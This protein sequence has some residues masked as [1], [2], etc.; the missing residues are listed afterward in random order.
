MASASG[1]FSASGSTRSDSFHRTD[2]L[3]RAH[4]DCLCLF[5]R[6]HRGCVTLEVDVGLVAHVDGDYFDQRSESCRETTVPG[7]ASRLAMRKSSALRTIIGIPTPRP[8][9]SERGIRPRPTGP[10]TLPRG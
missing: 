9:L 10:K 3:A 1:S 2:V 7:V 5:A 8:G 4:R 6:D